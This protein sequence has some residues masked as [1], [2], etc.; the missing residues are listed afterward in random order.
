MV[1]LSFGADAAYAQVIVD[2]DRA[3]HAVPDQ[4]HPTLPDFSMQQRASLYRSVVASTKEHHTVPVPADRQIVV[5]TVLLD[6]AQL[7]PAPEDVR[8]QIPASNNY[9]YAVWNSQ[10]LLVDPHK[11]EVVD[12]LHDFILRDYK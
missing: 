4:P 9:K 2:P 5:G 7:D 1:A 10:V 12:I 3:A 11:Q 6:P 8:A